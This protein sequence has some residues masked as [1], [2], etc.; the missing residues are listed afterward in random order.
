MAQADRSRRRV[1]LGV[2]L[3]ALAGVVILTEIVLAPTMITDTSEGVDFVPQIELLFVAGGVGAVGFFVRRA[4]LRLQTDTRFRAARRD[5]MN[6][7]LAAAPPPVSAAADPF[8]RD[9]T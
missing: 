2:A 7:E 9:H 3:L 1:R 6:E 5:R 4:G 8:F